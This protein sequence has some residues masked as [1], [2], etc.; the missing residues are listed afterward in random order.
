M[1]V[2]GPGLILKS[3]TK[4]P[5]IQVMKYREG[6]YNKAFL[7]TFDNGFEVVAK[8]PNPNA[9]P[10]HWTTASEVAT[11]DYV[12]DCPYQLML[13]FKLKSGWKARTILNL[14]VPRVLSWD[15]DASNPIESEYI[16]MEKVKGVPLSQTWFGLSLT[17]KYKI[18]M[19]IVDIEARLCSATF[20]THGCLYY[21]ANTTEEKNHTLA[22]NPRERFRIGPVVDP[23]LWRDER[24][25]MPL[26]R[27]PCQF[28]RVFFSISCSANSFYRAHFVRLR[29]K[30]GAE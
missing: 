26:S 20:P 19:Q 5:G 6:Q 28:H 29:H 8:L 14:P 2:L 10:Q 22:S 27:G 25:D 12:S 21:T 1:Y 4:I 17:T 7:L 11:M 24:Y 3:L 30:H 9:G 18:I 15:C 16:I 23:L 13:K